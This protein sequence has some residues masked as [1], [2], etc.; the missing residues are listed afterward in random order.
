MYYGG[1]FVDIVLIFILCL[2]WSRGNRQ[3]TKV[4]NVV[5]SWDVSDFLKLKTLK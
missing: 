5:R 3:R 4:N 2:Q 1:D